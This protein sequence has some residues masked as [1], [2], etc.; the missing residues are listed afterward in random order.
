MF[1]GESGSGRPSENTSNRSTRR[2]MRSTSDRMSVE[3]GFS[4]SGSEPSSSCAA[5]RMPESG[6]LISC[7]SIEAM[8]PT[9]RTASR[10]VRCRFILSMMARGCNTSTRSPAFSP[11]G[12][13]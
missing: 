13:A 7:A 6:F 2:T 4:T 12:A 1:T 3:S 9:E 11:N 5:P 8:A 10:C